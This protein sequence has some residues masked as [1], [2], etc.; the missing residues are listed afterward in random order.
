PVWRVPQRNPGFT[1]RAALLEG[2]RGRLSAS[3]LAAPP[4]ALF[5]LG[6]VG[7]TQ[8][9]LEY[10]HRFAADYDVI[11]WISASQPS[12]VR[13]ALA[14]LAEE[15]EL[16]TGSVG[17]SVENVLDALRRGEPYRRWLLVFDNAGEPEQIREYLPQGTGHV[18]VTTRNLAWSRVAAVV[19]V[20]VFSRAESVAFLRQRV[21]ALTAGEADQVAEKLGDLPL[22]IEQAGAWLAVTAMPSGRYLELLDT[23]LPQVLEENPPPGYERTAAATW[24][25][26]LE[27]L[28][29]QMP[30]A[31]KLL[32]LC[33]FFAPEPIP[34][35]LLISERFV[36]A[37]VP[38]DPT[39]N[40]P[41]MQ[42]RLIREIGKYALA[43]IDAG[44]GG[45]EQR[46]VQ[47]H[48]LVQA[49]I[50]NHLTEEAREDN[51]RVVHE[52]LAA[53]N[54]KNPDDSRRWPDYGQLTPHLVPSG[55]IASPAAGVRQLVL[56]MV[57]YLYQ[58]GDAAS[59]QDVAEAALAAWRASEPA[60]SDLPR[61]RLELAN[62]LWSQG[63]YAEAYEIDQ[64][65]Y[66][67]LNE[68]FGPD[69]LYTIRGLT[70]Q[71]ADLRGL[72][73]YAEARDLDEEALTRLRLVS[74]E[75]DPMTLLAA[76]NLAV[77]LRLVGDFRAAAHID[78]DVLA[79][80]RNILGPGH[81]HTVLSEINYG[82][83]LRDLG[84]YGESRRL[85]EATLSAA[86]RDLGENHHQALRAAKT[87]AVTMRKL[88]ELRAAHALSLDTLARYNQVLGRNHRDTLACANNLACDL[89]ANGDDVGAR[90][91]AEEALQRARDRLGHD[92]PHTLAWTNNLAIFLR[93]LGEHAAAKRLND[94]A[95]E[96]FNRI[97]GPGHPYTLACV[98][99]QANDLFNLG[100]YSAALRAD[101]EAHAAL[102]V[103]L[104]ER[105]PD[106]LALAN[107]LAASLRAAGDRAGSHRLRDEVLSRTLEHLGEHHP[108]TAA[109]RAGRRLNCDLDPPS[110]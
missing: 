46:G 57:R 95:L 36:A 64:R 53:A 63:R 88:G 58:S 38:L 61:I 41:L 52:I 83:D 102:S 100:E 8:V 1:G 62:A 86:R 104:G 75:T 84:R 30:A 91:T 39:L 79:M 103:A 35:S 29:D 5:G 43:R 59:S 110:L 105:H 10:A 70:G 20:G 50:R 67:E 33:A 94:G 55:A 45:T 37:L 65:A 23:Q 76:S 82:R 2:L 77:S 109:V 9:G 54:P 87:L 48:R 107:N 71:A 26:S 31:A 14:A 7:K 4:E 27:H 89:S 19:E 108:N 101:R 34:T 32:E 40:D 78:E 98:M 6:G 16:S 99:N 15:L 73:R 3:T 17:E 85:L 51:R 96:R 18:L 74:G 28:R 66:R 80:R 93:N 68:R 72:G 47:M 25:L 44:Q 21:P 97:Y 42:G 13:A 56:D 24:L 60:G 90:M 106:T 92:H 12:L 81:A 11:W 49:V 69:Y 22:A